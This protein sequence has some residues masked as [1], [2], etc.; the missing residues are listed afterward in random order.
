MFSRLEGN[1]RSPNY[2]LLLLA[3]QSLLLPTNVTPPY[4]ITPPSC[5]KFLN[6]RKKLDKR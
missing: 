6:S 1:K 4:V 2:K 5:L 3:F